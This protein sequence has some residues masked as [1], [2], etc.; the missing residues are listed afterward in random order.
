MIQFKLL[1]S[2]ITNIELVPLFECKS[3]IQLIIENVEGYSWDSDLQLS[4]VQFFATQF[5]Q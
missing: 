5:Q 2:L 1:I 3:S 4:K